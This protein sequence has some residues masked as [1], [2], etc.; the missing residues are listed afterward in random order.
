VQP[1]LDPP[2]T[3]D[4]LCTDAGGQSDVGDEI[5]DLAG[6]LPQAG[7]R[8]ALERVAGDADN[9]RDVIGPFGGGV[10]AGGGAGIEDLDQA[11][12]V[13]RSPLLIR[14]PDLIHRRR[15]PADLGNALVQGGLVGFDLGDEVGPDR[16]NLLKCF[17][18]SAGRQPS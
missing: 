1:V 8:D 9:R 17:F 5:R 6:S 11:D 7:R 16:G 13:A 4:S 18:D 15:A 3:A 2:M 10:Q 12:F 14:G